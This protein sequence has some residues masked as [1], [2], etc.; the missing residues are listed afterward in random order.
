VK[1]IAAAHD[2]AKLQLEKKEQER[3]KVQKQMAELEAKVNILALIPVRAL[4]R[5]SMVEFSPGS[6]FD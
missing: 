1:S 3:M 2:D 6:L 5:S 4:F